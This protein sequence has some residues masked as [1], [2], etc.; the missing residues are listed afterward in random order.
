MVGL[1]R[2]PIYLDSVGTVLVAA[3]CGPRMGAVT[4][5]LSCLL[6]GLVGGP[7]AIPFAV[8]AA[9]VGGLA[10]K[11]CEWGGLRSWPARVAAGV[12]IGVCGAACSAPIA[13]WLFGGVTGGSTDLLVLLYRALGCSVERAVFLQGLT[14]DP[15][16]KVCTLAIVAW[17][18]ERS[19]RRVLAQYPRA[20][21]AL[22]DAR[23]SGTPPQAPARA[24]DPQSPTRGTP[25]C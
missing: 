18:L 3:L 24:T 25:P 2:L 14:A 20:A 4:G 16:D 9:M 23:A 5:G 22:A 12:V 7:T 19:P 15:L 17:I 13:T 8:V 21:W 6:Q 1:I 10:G 11:L